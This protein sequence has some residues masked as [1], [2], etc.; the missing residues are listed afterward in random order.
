MIDV[1]CLAATTACSLL[2]DL[3]VLGGF[4]N[5]GQAPPDLSSSLGDDFEFERGY[6]Y[7]YE[8]E[9]KKWEENGATTVTATQ[10]Q[11]TPTTTTAAAITTTTTTKKPSTKATT[12]AAT[13]R[14]KCF[15]VRNVQLGAFSEIEAEF[16]SW[17][18]SA[19]KWECGC[20][21][22]HE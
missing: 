18:N 8:V 15:S 3:L 22:K 9:C 17:R 4:G 13:A 20:R 5:E 2:N 7:V 1:R 16:N 19:T 6:I 11:S 14:D 21:W 12:G 10:S